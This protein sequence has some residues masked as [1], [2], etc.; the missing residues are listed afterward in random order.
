[1]CIITIT[2][3]VILVQLMGFGNMTSIFNT[4]SYGGHINQLGYYDMPLLIQTILVIL[5]QT[6]YDLYDLS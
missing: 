5:H 6:D 1:M 4:C 2:I 3:D